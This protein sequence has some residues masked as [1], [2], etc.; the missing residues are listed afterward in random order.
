M[1]AY[2]VACYTI[3]DQEGYAPYPEAVAPT[4]VTYG[5][6]LIVGDFESHVLEGASHPVTV[7]VKFPSEVAALDWYNSPE[8]LAVVNLRTDHS[9]GTAVL[10]DQWVMPS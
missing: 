5:G 9:V 8:Y 3:T 2:L 1:T 7:V 4:L 10:V 6:E